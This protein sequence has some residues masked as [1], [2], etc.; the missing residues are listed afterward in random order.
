MSLFRPGLLCLCGR[1]KRRKLISPFTNPAYRSNC[2]RQIKA[3]QR[4]DYSRPLIFYC[5]MQR[6]GHTNAQ[7]RLGIVSPPK[8]GRT[9]VQYHVYR[10]LLWLKPGTSRRTEL[11]YPQKPGRNIQRLF[12]PRHISTS[13]TTPPRVCVSCGAAGIQGK[14]EL[15]P[16]DGAASLAV[17]A[18]LYKNRAPP[19]NEYGGEEADNNE[20]RGRPHRPGVFH[21]HAHDMAYLE[22]W[23]GEMLNIWRDI[24]GVAVDGPKRG[25]P[26]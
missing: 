8:N 11:L 24:D 3:Q 25:P 23:I 13:Q 26:P 14:R 9:T 5:R 15:V 21:A 6:V 17:D 4:L 20:T 10:L 12:P 2:E 16:E 19:D 1:S 18:F 7:R 22:E